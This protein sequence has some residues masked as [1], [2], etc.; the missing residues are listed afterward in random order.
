MWTFTK[1]S[2]EIRNHVLAAMR[3]AHKVIKGGVKHGSRVVLYTGKQIFYG[4]RYF[5]SKYLAVQ[6]YFA[7][8]IA[9]G[10]LKAILSLTSRSYN[11]TFSLIHMVYTYSPIITMQ[12]RR[13]LFYSCRRVAISVQLVSQIHLRIIVRIFTVLLLPNTMYAFR[14]LTNVVH[15]FV[16]TQKTH[17]LHA[18]PVTYGLI[19]GVC[20]LAAKLIVFTQQVGAYSYQQ[21]FILSRKQTFLKMPSGGALCYAQW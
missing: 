17:F 4:V 21:A 12:F 3:T 13:V 18:F 11:L 1:L 7:R 20:R 19:R 2:Q 6:L 10:T 15:H 16:Q 8:R 5:A 14:Q 9:S